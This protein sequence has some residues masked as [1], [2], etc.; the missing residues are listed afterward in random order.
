MTRVFCGASFAA[1]I[2]CR[3]YLLSV[4]KLIQENTYVFE[5][6]PGIIAQSLEWEAMREY[7]GEFPL[8]RVIAGDYAAFDKRMSSTIILAAFDIILAI[9][10]RAGYTE[11]QLRVVRGIA[12]DTAFPHVD[13]N[14]DLVAFYGSNPSGHSL[15]V[16]INGL[17][18]ALY[19]RYCFEMLGGDAAQFKQ[20]VKLMTYGD[21]NIMTVREGCDFFN[22]TSIQ[23]VL[24]EADIT[25]TMAEKDAASVPFISIDQ[26]SFLK[27]EWRWDPDVGAY[28]APL[29]QTSFDKMLTTRVASKIVTP[30]CH[31][32]DVI[33]S[34]IREYFFYGKE[35]F[36]QKTAMF[37]DVVAECEL[38]LFVKDSTF[39]TWE[40]LYDNFWT[41]S[42]HVNLKREF[43]RPQLKIKQ[44]TWSGERSITS[45]GPQIIDC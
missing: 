36:E 24:A 32:I 19:M 37:R 2:V 17:V 20:H 29:D 40:Q 13:Y 28:M 35:I 8:D 38:E 44:P 45:S 27:R 3:K 7:L 33:G 23:R 43:V 16:I 11:E 9:C 41:N 18:N 5:S 42:Q 21:D 1:T 22:H 39:P 25:Y 15:T 6:A 26:A 4:I 31:S 30:Q 12:Y 10:E 14:G 34:A